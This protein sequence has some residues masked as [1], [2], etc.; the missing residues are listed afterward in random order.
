M[1]LKQY[2]HKQQWLSK[3]FLLN[4]HHGMTLHF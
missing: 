2:N 3:E 4:L 1:K